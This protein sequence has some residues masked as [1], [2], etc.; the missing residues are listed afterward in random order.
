MV[1]VNMNGKMDKF[2][3]DNGLMDLKVDLACGEGQ[4]ETPTLVNGKTVKPMDMESIHGLMETDMRVNLSNVSNMVKEFKNL[5]TVMFTG[6][7]TKVVSHMAM[8]NIY[9]VMEAHTKV[10]LEKVFGMEK[11]YGK[12]QMNL[13][14]IHMKESL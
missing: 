8:E 3:R 13:K 1:M 11:D 9:G 14:L 6:D 7:F 10:N 5:Q 2:I 4:K 12:S